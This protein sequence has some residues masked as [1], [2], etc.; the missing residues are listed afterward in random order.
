MFEQIPNFVGQ[1]QNAAPFIVIAVLGL[2][3]VLAIENWPETPKG[4]R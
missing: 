4:R 3:I 1:V 2:L